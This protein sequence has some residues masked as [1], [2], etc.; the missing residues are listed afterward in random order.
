MAAMLC[1]NA[2]RGHTYVDMVISA[3]REN[4]EAL[5][6]KGHMHVN[7]GDISAAFNMCSRAYALAPGSAAAH[8]LNVALRKFGPMTRKRA[9][10]N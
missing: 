1:P 5:C 3:N 2:K 7:D 10:L 9:R 4:V 8:R 6:I